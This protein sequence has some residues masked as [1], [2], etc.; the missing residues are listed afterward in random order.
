MWSAGARPAP[1]CS[2]A[3]PRRPLYSV[4]YRRAYAL[5]PHAGTPTSGGVI[6]EAHA[7]NSPLRVVPIEDTAGGPA[8]VPAR[9]SLLEPDDDGVVITA[10]KAADDGDGTIVRLHEAFGGRRRVGL[11]S[12]GITRADRVDLL[13]APMEGASPPVLDGVIDLELRPFEL[14]TLRLR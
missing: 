5:Y 12:P 8:D 3:S 6:A 7:F 11:R 10:L 1:S 9:F 14:V 4:R 2:A 13:E